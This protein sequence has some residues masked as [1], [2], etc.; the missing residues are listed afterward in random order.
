[1]FRERYTVGETVSVGYVEEVR[2]FHQSSTGQVT[3]FVTPKFSSPLGG[4]QPS[5]VRS[6]SPSRTVHGF[7]VREETRREDGRSQKY[8]QPLITVFRSS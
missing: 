4:F 6:E 3:P 1:M 5:P 8:L 7:E 2:T